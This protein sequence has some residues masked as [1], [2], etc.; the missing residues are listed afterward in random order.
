[1]SR[2]PGAFTPDARAAILTAAL[3]ACVGCRRPMDEA[4]HRR[5]R[6]MGGTTN[7]LIGEP[8]NGLALCRRCH[9]W[10]ESNRDHARTLGWL[11]PTPSPDAPYWTSHYG[12]CVWVLL[13]DGP[14]TWC[15]APFQNPPSPAADES[16]RAWKQQH[17]K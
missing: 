16:A 10:A 3:H 6:G 2:G 4:H 17:K 11:T 5:P 15:I 14:A 7:T 1:M 13:D 8:W 12:W 9:A